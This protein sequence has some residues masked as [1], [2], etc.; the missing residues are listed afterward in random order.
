MSIVTVP[1]ISIK[2]IDALI[3]AIFATIHALVFDRF[4]FYMVFDN[5]KAPVL[6][7]LGLCR[8]SYAINTDGLG[9]QRD[10]WG[11]HECCE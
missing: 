2:G 5:A 3:A 9:W 1:H 7:L 6:V 10:K 4:D 11:L 8:K